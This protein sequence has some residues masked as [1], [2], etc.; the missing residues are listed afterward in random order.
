LVEGDYCRLKEEADQKKRVTERGAGFFLDLQ[1]GWNAVKKRERGC[2][3]RNR[4]EERG[5]GGGFFGKMSK[6]ASE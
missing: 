6:R 5:R 4:L 2:G 3:Q 1:G